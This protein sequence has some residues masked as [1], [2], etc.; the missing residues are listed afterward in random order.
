MQKFYSDYNQ[1]KVRQ[2][3][4]L[5]D[6]AGIP[7]FVKNEYIQGASGEIPPHETL[8]EVWLVDNAW[9]AKAQALLEQFE[10]DLSEYAQEVWHCKKC[11]EQNEG[12]FLICWQCQQSR[13]SSQLS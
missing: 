5:L 11:Q 13:P 8:P 7:C 9:Y 12:Q 6:D 2:I 3:K 1:V 10:Q 4:S